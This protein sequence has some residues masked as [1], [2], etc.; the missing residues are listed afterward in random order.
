MKKSKRLRRS[1]L[2]LREKATTPLNGTVVIKYLDAQNIEMKLQND[3][4]EI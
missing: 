4:D 2:I 1:P 3:L